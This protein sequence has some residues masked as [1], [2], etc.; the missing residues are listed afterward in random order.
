VWNYTL[1]GYQVLKK[2]LSYREQP[3]LGRALTFDEVK[4]FTSIAR[5]IAAL[6]LL[7]D[8][9]DANYAAAAAG[10]TPSGQVMPESARPRATP[11]GD[12]VIFAKYS[13]KSVRGDGN[14][15]PML[16][17]EKDIFAVIDGDP[18]DKDVTAARRPEPDAAPPP[19]AS[20]GDRKAALLK[21]PRNVPLWFGTNREPNDRQ[22]IALGFSGRRSTDQSVWHGRCV[23]NVPQGHALGSTGTGGLRGWWQRWRHGVD[24]RLRLLL[25]EGLGE[26]DFWQAVRAAMTEH[27][28]RKPEALLF[29]HGYRVS[30]ED[31]ALR[32]AQLAYD[33]KIRD[34]LQLAF[35]RRR[36]AIPG[37]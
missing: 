18:T 2:W 7:R 4:T 23:V 12:P 37:R 22:R 11:Q 24:D 15:E 13:G 21:D 3:L 6:V 36:G 35:G 5:R 29:L 25:V 20:P 19:V 9:L 32:A 34:I 17:S 16:L 26:L 28:D 31:A 10:H 27:D 14:D 30:F 8:R 1:G 33:L